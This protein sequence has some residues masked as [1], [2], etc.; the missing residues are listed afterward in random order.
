MKSPCEPRG[1]AVSAVTGGGTVLP[2]ARRLSLELPPG[3]R[4][5][6]CVS[7]QLA[8]LLSDCS[9]WPDAVCF[10]EGD[11]KGEAGFMRE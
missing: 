9:A 2:L 8:M 3:S 7:E 1:G 11:R 10:P 4:C 6:E 5:M